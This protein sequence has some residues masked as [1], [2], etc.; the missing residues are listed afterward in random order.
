MI[1]LIAA[2]A[3][4][5]IIGKEGGIP[6]NIPADLAHFK[7]LTLGQTVIM[8]RRT[9]ESIG[10]PLPGRHNIVVS[11]TLQSLDGCTVAGSLQEALELAAETDGEIF[12]IGG[13][14]LYEE[15]LPLAEQLDLTLVEGAPEGDTYFPAVNWDSFR[16]V[17]RITCDSVPGCQFV[18]F[19]RGSTSQNGQM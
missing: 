1:H 5:G 9:Y 18:T 12:I 6:W 10:R 17:E 7:A 2:V 4:N 11:T 3:E 8:G 16:E 15:A 19:V 13:A 14:R